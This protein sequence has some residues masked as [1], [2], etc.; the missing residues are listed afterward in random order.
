MVKLV[1]STPMPMPVAKRSE[2]IIDHLDGGSCYLQHIYVEGETEAS[3]MQHGG[4]GLKV[5]I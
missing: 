1:P 5:M 4:K 2:L 3:S